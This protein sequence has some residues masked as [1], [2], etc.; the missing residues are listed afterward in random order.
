MQTSTLKGYR[1]NTVHSPLTAWKTGTHVISTRW[2]P[3]YALSTLFRHTT[4]A[5]SMTA[6][7]A[8]LRTSIFL[9]P[10]PKYPMDNP[11][12]K[13]QDKAPYNKIY[14]ARVTKRIFDLLRDRIIKEQPD[15]P[16]EELSPFDSTATQ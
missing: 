14:T 4:T 9:Q 16:T 11:V 13:R 10:V 15:Q 2:S 12:P 1:F 6:C 7:N 8:W 3:I 5:F